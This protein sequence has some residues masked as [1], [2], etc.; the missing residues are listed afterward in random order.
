MSI[1]KIKWQDLMNNLSPSSYLFYDT[2]GET[3]K[4]TYDLIKE[5]DGLI[6]SIIEEESGYIQTPLADLVDY[7][8][9][10]LFNNDEQACI[11]WNMPLYTSTYIEKD[12][13]FL[14]L[15][16]NK[17][18]EYLAFYKKILTDEGVQ[19]HLV[20]DKEYENDGNSDNL[21][22]GINSNTPQN[23]S[24]YDSEHPESD[25]KFDQA[26]ADYASTIDKNKA[27]T[28]SHTEGSSGTTVSG[29][30][31]EEG[32]KNIQMMFFN[33]LKDYIFSLPERIYSFYSLETIPAPEITK[34]FIEHLYEV[35]DML[36]NE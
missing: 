27:H 2:V 11:W 8:D 12:A 14:F 19:R 3:D 29:T 30:T 36:L 6:D 35:R 22:R 4:S 13:R 23:S 5:I 31:W 10:N 1:K 32:K 7:I 17:L 28:T 33:E 24:L 25:A 16:K 18:R 9:E 26:I 34:K 21:E 15:L 20:Y